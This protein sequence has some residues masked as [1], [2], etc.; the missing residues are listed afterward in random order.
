MKS[1]ILNVQLVVNL[2]QCLKNLYSLNINKTE[3]IKKKNTMKTI[4][5]GVDFTKSSDNTINYAV[6]LAK[7][8]SSKLLL[9]HTLTA[10][11]IHTTSGL[12]F[13]E[14]DILMKDTEKE[15]QDLLAR[16]KKKHPTLKINIEITY[17]RIRDRVKKL[18]KN[19]K[20]N[21]VVLGLENKSKIQKF[22]GSTT[23]L[24]LAG[25]IDCPV[26]TVSEKYKNHSLK[27]M[28]IA[29]DNKD[30]LKSGQSK[31]IHSIIEVLG[32][33]AEFVHIKTED[34]LNIKQSHNRQI[35]ISTIEADD[36]KTGI[37]SYAKKTKADIIMLISNKYS[38]LHS[39]FIDSHSKQ[40]ILSS[41]IPVISVHK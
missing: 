1:D 22:L 5:V 19:K 29:I 20:I 4:L 11:I 37:T 21:L 35:T 15:M 13:I 14:N 12:V 8:S 34:E 6:K 9:F 28:L 18:A 38:A 27:N 36:F 32:V 40:I 23:S 17:D 26:I 10:P 30:N 16:Y 33:K 41:K 2:V 39:L 25:K 7:Q 3:L 31:R 24:D